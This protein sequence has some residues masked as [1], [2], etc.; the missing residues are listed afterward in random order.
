MKILLTH[1][2]YI[3]YEAKKKAIEAAEPI[4]KDKE[5]VEDC[6]VAFCSAEEGDDEDIVGKVV[7]E[8]DK[9]AKQ[10][11]TKTVV[12]YPFVHLTSTPAKP[13]VALDIV[14]KIDASLQSNY[15]THRA[16]FG[17]YKSLN[18]KTKGHPLSELSREIRLDAKGK[19]EM[20]TKKAN[21]P[22][23]KGK[24]ILDRRNLPPND[25]R[26]LGEELG[27]FH[28]SEEIGAGLPLWM[29][30][31]ET[32]RNT[33]I[34]FMREM[35]EKYGYKYVST[36]HITRGAL[37]E[38]TGHLPYYKD[39]MYPPIELEGEDYYLR[40]MNCPH[41][42][43]IYNKLVESY[44]DLP[45]RLSEPGMDYRNEL[46]GVTYGLIRV[47]C[48]TQN[49][50]HIYV[51]PEQLKTEFI[52]VLQLFKE[53][54]DIM[55]IKDY[56]YRLSLPD[57]KE[58]P[59]KY[60]GDPKEW[61]HACEEI[62]QAMKDFGAK[63]VEETGEAAF[64]GPKIDVQIKNTLG[65][66]ESIATSQIDIVIPKRLD[67][68]YI[69]ANGEKKTPIIIHRAILGSFE[70]AIAYL[71]EQTEGKLPVWLAPVQVKVLSLTDRNLDGV[72]NIYKMLLE[73]GIRAEADVA[74][75]T[76]DYKIRS[77]ELQ[78]TPYMIVI[79]DKEE[80]NNTLAVRPRGEKPQFGVKVEDFLA[81]I[82][83]EIDSKSR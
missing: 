22:Q 16:P 59:D 20:V 38:K 71:L 75:H 56:W 4:E 66:E 58:N 67:M 52:S 78:R 82:R 15:E 12:V 10:V 73:N 17:W 44:R 40:P 47:R 2:D 46:S 30:Y 33:L 63:F 65:K 80:Q 72:K 34:N 42:H 5:R 74:P 81:K 61:A 35:E 69:D 7:E 13:A 60:T 43:M 76:I 49:D 79:G 55:G 51:T 62:R 21:K 57:F 70:R 28:L 3:E 31:G 39:S 50:S 8:I 9:V 36:P 48:F 37:Y 18:I 14:K 25:H 19:P 11:N 64:Y 68:H 26:I 45:L 32:L 83:K 41:H 53:V 6:L 24:I 27:I 54:Y 23:T 29:P 1:C 77:G